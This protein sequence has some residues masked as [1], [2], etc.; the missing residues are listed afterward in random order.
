M[1]SSKPPS[2]R[3]TPIEKFIRDGGKVDRRQRWVEKQKSIGITRV[4]LRV[5]VDDE[6]ALRDF[7]ASLLQKRQ[8]R[9]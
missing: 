3:A 1:S 9:D 5:H 8:S 6:K 7:A 4:L 2:S